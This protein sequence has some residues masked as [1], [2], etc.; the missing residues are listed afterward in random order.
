MLRFAD[1]IVLL[2]EKCEDV[3]ELLNG[4]GKLLGEDFGLTINKS[5][6]KVMKCSRNDNANN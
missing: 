1:D 3:E 2:A 4:M 6:T 5:K